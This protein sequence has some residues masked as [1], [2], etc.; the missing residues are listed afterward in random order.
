MKLEKLI[1][2]LQLGMI[3]IVLS[4]CTQK[5][6]TSIEISGIIPIPNKVTNFKGSFQIND[7]SKIFFVTKNLSS[8]AQLYAKELNMKTVTHSNKKAT[9]SISLNIDTNLVLEGY[10]IKISP[11]KITISGGD[12]AGV[13]YALQTLRQ[14]KTDKGFPAVEI[15][16]APRFPYRGMML[17]V[18]RYFFS[19]KDVKR[20]IDIMALH[21]FN[22]FHWHL[23]DDQGWRIEIKKYPKL[24]EIGSIR[25][26]T[27]KGDF[28]DSHV[29]KVLWEEQGKWDFRKKYVPDPNDFDGKPHGGFYSQEDIKDIVK[30][31]AEKYIEII[32]EIDVPGHF[33]AA[34]AAYPEFGCKESYEVSTR[35]SVHPNILC[36]TE[37]SIDFVK[38]ILT[39]VM[40]LFPSEYVHIGGD[41]ANKTH[42]EDSKFCQDFI[43]ESNLVDEMGLQSYFI[44]RLDT[45]LKSKGKKLIGWDEILE[46]GLSENAV[47]M[48]WQGEVGGIEAAKLGH[49][50]IMSPGS[51]TY[52]DKYQDSLE[53][54]QKNILAQ[55]GV[56]SLKKAYN[57]NP[58]PRELTTDEQKYVIGAEG[59]MWTEY[60]STMDYLEYMALPRAAALA[61]VVW[62]KP[63]NKNW[64]NF[65]NRLQNLFK[66]YELNGYNYA[67][68]YVKN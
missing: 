4:S 25:K 26:E 45:F 30:Y 55:W 21:K 42:W 52:F 7:N 60:I 51:H 13:F 8:I 48:S 18:S 5:E 37:K 3:L 32:P 39:E 50:V 34:L 11:E 57:Y 16:D 66:L 6:V 46:G 12:T 2:S 49:N 22:K 19:V 36:P 28:R 41:E 15:N 20:F 53:F 24:T 47:V 29:R 27:M 56:I 31:A 1:Y 63:E 43:M 62:S 23:T 68:H 33:S 10:H 58:L 65:N 40:E 61:E 59:C 38:D 35:W 64:N 9:N 44:G 17:D 67:K 14:L 54:K